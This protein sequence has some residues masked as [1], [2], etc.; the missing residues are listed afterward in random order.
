MLSL[1]NIFLSFYHV[2]IEQGFFNELSVC[3]NIIGGD[4]AQ[5]LLKNFQKKGISSCKDVPFAIFGFSLATINLVVNLFLMLFYWK[6][7]KYEKKN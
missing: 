7:V 3:K 5:D 2:G 6:I 4:N 1:I